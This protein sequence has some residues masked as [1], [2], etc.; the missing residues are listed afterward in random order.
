MQLKDGRTQSSVADFRRELIANGKNGLQ[1]SRLSRTL[2]LFLPPLCVNCGKPVRQHSCLCA[3]CWSRIDFFAPPLCDVTGLPL[4]FD[5]LAFELEPSETDA[6]D[7]G[8]GRHLSALAQKKKLA[9]DRARFVAHY[10][11]VMRELVRALKYG[12]RREA[13][14]LFARWMAQAGAELLFDADLLLPV[15]LY[16][17]RLWLRRFNQAVLLT[18]QLSNLT[19][20]PAHMLALKRKRATRSQVGLSELERRRNVAGA[21]MV[22]KA[23]RE[24]VSGRK[25]VL[26]DDVLTTGATAESCARTLRSVG[27][28]RVD[29]LALARVGSVAQELA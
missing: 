9:Y 23:R 11:G 20:V 17:T 25:I 7:S 26:I 5:Y 27:A 13:L 22:H 10:S 3:A 29:I 14:P 8:G 15:P 28:K 4:P 16:R 21:F 6:F 2:D 19:G 1:R 24:L 12:D 18:R